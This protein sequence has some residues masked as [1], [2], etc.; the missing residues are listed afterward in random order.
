LHLLR[1]GA[2]QLVR[3]AKAS[4]TRGA[5]DGAAPAYAPGPRQETHDPIIAGKIAKQRYMDGFYLFGTDMTAAKATAKDWAKSANEYRTMAEGHL[6]AEAFARDMAEILEKSG[7]T[8]EQVFKDEV[9]K[10]K[11]KLAGIC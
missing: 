7:K 1:L 11:A 5:G 4:S 3:D 8:T 6:R 9:F 10:E 2:D